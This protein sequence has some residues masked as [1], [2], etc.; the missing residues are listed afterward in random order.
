[1]AQHIAP[2]SLDELEDDLIDTSVP[3]DDTPTPASEKN[4]GLKKMALK[5]S[6]WSFGGFGVLAILRFISYP[7]MARLVNQNLLGAMAVIDTAL[8]GFVFISDVGINL[9]IIRHEKGSTP[10]FQN[11]AWTIQVMR[12]FL[13]F[14]LIS[15]LAMPIAQFTGIN[16]T[17]SEINLVATALPIAGLSAIFLG[18]QS[19]KLA[20]AQRDINTRA[21]V[22]IDV[23]AYSLS[24]IARIAWAV[25]SPTI[26]ALVV[27]GLVDSVIKLIGSWILRDGIRNRL[28]WNAESAKAI[29]VFG[30]WILISTALTYAARESSNLVMARKTDFV[31]MAEFRM[32]WL[33]ASM[34][35]MAIMQLG[36]KVMYP[37]FSTLLK[38]N[39]HKRFV[40][41]LAKARL[42]VIGIAWVI[43][44]GVI[45]VGPTVASYLFA[46]DNW[47]RYYWIMP[48]L[49][50][51]T[52]FMIVNTSYDNAVIAL[53][54]TLVNAG[55]QGV[56]FLIIVASIFLGFEFYGQIGAV[57]GFGFASLIHYPIKAWWMR[58]LGIWQPRIDIP[59]L[60]GA[61]AVASLLVWVAF[62][63]Y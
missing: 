54:K 7:I 41:A 48:I 63:I 47:F 32:A 26:W 60:I 39:D 4:G 46:E 8:L 22:S 10:A 50:A 33:W 35:L 24:L 3:T 25:V 11:T 5:G 14:S 29:W 44:A 9:S 38:E 13:L 15:F 40:S 42:G 34:G 23:I 51:G 30:R 49:G 61:A 52:M 57:V 37:T 6:V 59:C 27:G 45:I 55:L 21:L 43:A 17:P 19:T 16:N 62:R 2:P 58:K 18:F 56:Y 36:W 31:F 20:I 1:M 53:E 28:A 12:G